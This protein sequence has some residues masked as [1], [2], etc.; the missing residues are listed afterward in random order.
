MLGPLHQCART[1][2]DAEADELTNCQT[3]PRARTAGLIRTRAH[4]VRVRVLCDV[5]LR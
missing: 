5:A 3:R 4:V 1:D 2:D